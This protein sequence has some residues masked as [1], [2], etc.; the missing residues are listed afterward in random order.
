MI[1]SMTDGI[2]A[3]LETYRTVMETVTHLQ[4]DGR[5]ID[6]EAIRLLFNCAEICHATASLLRGA[7]VR[8]LGLCAEL[9]ERSAAWCEEFG[10]DPRLRACAEACRRCADH[11]VDLAVAAAA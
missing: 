9:C 10:D 5:R 11:C 3:C 6:A 4:G 7:D 2:T 1:Q 8:A